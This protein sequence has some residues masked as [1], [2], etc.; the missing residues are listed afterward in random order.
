MMTFKK[1]SV[2]TAGGS[3]SIA[4]ALAAA[5]ADD[6]EAVHMMTENTTKGGRPTVKVLCGREGPAYRGK[7]RPGLMTTV[8][9]SD[10]TCEECHNQP[11]VSLWRKV[12]GL[13]GA[14]DSE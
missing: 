7:G 10:V 5:L 8:W 2:G 3:S 11:S 12:K 6:L 14:E 1:R 4:P 9:P 13:T